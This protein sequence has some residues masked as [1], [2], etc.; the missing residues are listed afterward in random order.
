MLLMCSHTWQRMFFVNLFFYIF[1][2]L[3]SDIGLSLY[4]T[5]LLSAV[6]FILIKMN[7]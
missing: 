2:I 3:V 7:K 4:V 6:F 1:Y 5:S